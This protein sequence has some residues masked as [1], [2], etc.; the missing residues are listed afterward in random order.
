MKQLGV[1]TVFTT[2]YHPQSNPTERRNRDIKS[3][4]RKFCEEKHSHWDDHIN[5]MLYALRS[6]KLK[7]TK[8]TPAMMVFGRE[9]TGPVDIL[10]SSLDESS[11][12]LEPTRYL[13]Q[14]QLRLRNAVKYGIENKELA[15]RIGKIQYDKHRTDYEFQIGDL[16]LLDEHPLSKKAIGYAAGLAPQRDGPYKV[17]ARENRLNYRLEYIGSTKQKGETV[18]AHIAQMTKYVSRELETLSPQPVQQ[19]EQAAVPATPDLGLGKKRGRKAGKPAEPV[20]RPTEDAA[21]HLDDANRRVTRA[22]TK[23]LVEK[24]TEE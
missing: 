2:P 19:T 16:V 22:Q 10:T 11:T 13:D 23:K 7:T 5:E 20:L 6:T 17:V 15:H 3:Y 1:K 8:Q 24:V 18:W 9:L 12:T 14:V 21:E 4:I